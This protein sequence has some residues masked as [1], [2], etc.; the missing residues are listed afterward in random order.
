MTLCYI[1]CDTANSHC[2]SVAGQKYHVWEPHMKQLLCKAD[3]FIHDKEAQTLTLINTTS[4]ASIATSVP[5]PMAMPTSAMASAGESLMPS[6]TMATL[7]PAC[8]SCSTLAT[9][10]EGSTSANTFLIP[11]WRR[12]REQSEKHTQTTGRVSLFLG[13]HTWAAMARAVLLLSPVI[14]TTSRPMLVRVCTASS[15]SGFTVSAMAIIAHSTSE[16]KK[17]N[18]Y[19]YVHFRVGK[20]CNWGGGRI[21]PEK[22]VELDFTLKSTTYCPQLQEQQC[23]LCAHAPS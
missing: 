13:L 3:T 16:H 21:K 20:S 22:I 5:V 6:P 4:A 11:T 17:N 12:G 18:N 9:L 8:C 14:S 10:C 7:L 15:A 2:L 19:F 1:Y 23:A